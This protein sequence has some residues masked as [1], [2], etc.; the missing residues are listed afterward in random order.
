M[1]KICLFVFV[2]LSIISC[3]EEATDVTCYG[4]YSI[5]PLDD[6]A[7]EEAKKSPSAQFLAFWTAMNCNYHMWDYEETFGID[8]DDVLNRYLP[9]FQ[10]FDQRVKDGGN[11]SDDELKNVYEEIVSLLHDGH[12][13]LSINNY[14]MPNSLLVLNYIIPQR[15]RVCKRKEAM[16]DSLPFMKHDYQHLK[17]YYTVAEDNPNRMVEHKELADS[18]AKKWYSSY[19]TYFYDYWAFSHAFGCFPDNI[20]YVRVKD[21]TL[22]KSLNPSSIYYNYSY[23][24]KIREWWH[25]WFEK[26]QTLHEDGKLRGM[27]VD[28]RSNFGGDANDHKYLLGALQTSG[29]NVFQ[30]GWQRVKNGIGRL[31]YIGKMPFLLDTYSE[32]HASITEP[33]VVLVNSYTGSMAEVSSLVAKQMDNAIVMGTTTW[34]GM[35]P[36]PDDYEYTYSGT[37]GSFGGPFYIYMPAYTFYTMDDMILESKGIE[38]DI[39]VPFNVELYNS[40]GR[41]SQLERALEYLRR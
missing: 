5:M 30:V 28:L 11:I 33:I 25:T 3:R 2:V 18:T 27:I 9:I 39:Y 1:K 12:L 13:V 29:N 23:S 4:Y 40:T 35:C 22:D 20:V 31:D 6:T 32:A 14:W 10:E 38:P 15:N 7:M 19:G 24:E 26:V 17:Y 21:F 16:S 36:L 41:D 37:V 34:G 8:W